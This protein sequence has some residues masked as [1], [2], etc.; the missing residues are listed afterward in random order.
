MDEFTELSDA[1]Y[2][3]RIEENIEDPNG[4]LQVTLV[5]AKNYV[6]EN[7]YK[8]FQINEAEF[9]DILDGDLSTFIALKWTINVWIQTAFF[10]KND[11]NIY[12]RLYGNY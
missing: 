9:N 3:F 7:G 2:L 1:N 5:D 11:D 12:I 6:S 8:P 10:I 4:V